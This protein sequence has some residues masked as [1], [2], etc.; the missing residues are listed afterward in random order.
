VS[1]GLG[2]YRFTSEDYLKE[3]DAMVAAWKAGD[4]E[5]VV[6][7]FQRSWTDG[8]HRMPEEIDPL[9]RERVRAMARNRIESAM[10]GRRLKQ[11]AID[12][13]SEL[14]V[15]MLVVV[16][17]LDVPGILEIADMLAVANRNAELVVVPG[18][19][20]MVNMEEPEEFKKLLLDYLDRF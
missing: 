15:P 16:G 13:L 1:S 9:V 18:A 10:E 11:P 14:D 3:R 12:R 2:G 8:P 7:A 19:A 20:H 4:F 6:E 17:E 5:N